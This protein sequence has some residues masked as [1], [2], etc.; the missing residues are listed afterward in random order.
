MQGASAGMSVDSVRPGELVELRNL[1]P[2]YPFCTFRLPDESPR[3]CME[4]GAGQWTGFEPRLNAVVIRPDVDEVVMTWCASAPVDQAF[5]PD[6]P[7]EIRREIS[8]QIDGG[9]R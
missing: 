1:H 3:V 7:D 4:L 6:D 5:R 9:L 8:W 2:V